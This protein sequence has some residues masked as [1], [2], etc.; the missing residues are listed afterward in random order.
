MNH[1]VL[2]YYALSESFRERMVLSSESALNFT[3][4]GRLRQLGLRAGLRKIWGLRADRITIVIEDDNSRPLAGPLMLIAALS[5][6][7]KIDVLWPGNVLEHVSRIKIAAHVAALLC[8]QISGRVAYFKAKRDLRRLEASPPNA[9]SGAPLKEGPILYLDANLPS[10]AAVGGS[11]GHIKGVIEGFVK[12]GFVV[13][14]AA[15]KVLPSS[16]PGARWLQIPSGDLYGFPP[17][18]NCHIFNRSYENRLEALL[19]ENRYSFI[20]QRMSVHNFTGAKLRAATGIPLVLEYNGSEVWT[21]AHWSEKLRLHDVAAKAELSSLRSADIVVTVSK[22][23]GDQVAAVGVPRERIVVYPNC[24][25]PS[26]FD[27]NRFS[28]SDVVTLRQ[29]LGIAPDATVA[30]FIGTFGAWHGADFL[31]RAIRRLILEDRDWIEAHKLT[32]L[33][34]GDGLKMPEVK[35][36]LGGSPFSRFV[37]LTGLI[38]QSEAPAYLSA[39]DIFLSPHIPNPDGSAFFGSPT[40][41][42]EYMAMGKPIVAS[43]LDQIGEVL[44]GTYLSEGSASDGPLAALFSPASEDDFLNALRKVVV[45]PEGAASMAQRAR[46]SALR[47]F[48]WARHVGAILERMEILGLSK[49]NSVVGC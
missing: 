3:P 30:T 41:L 33:L 25:D 6:S 15:S 18:L 47:S 19:K 42:F 1:N 39:S 5:G 43:D 17:E 45:D 23:L 32:F 12:E 8:A 21:A 29:R 22:V 20:Y 34:I 49:R 4:I 46:E 37:T 48:T 16:L 36:L 2:S 11:V 26:V 10:G 24:I 27:P 38:P 35:E 7:G 31:A 40:K 9:L 44:R 14:Y 13:D 28:N